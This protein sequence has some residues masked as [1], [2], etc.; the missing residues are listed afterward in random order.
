MTFQIVVVCTILS[1]LTVNC[2]KKRYKLQ[3]CE[4]VFQIFCSKWNISSEENLCSCCLIYCSVLR[5]LLLHPVASGETHAQTQDASAAEPRLVV[6]VILSP[7]SNPMTCA[8]QHETWVTLDCS[9]IILFW[10]M[11]HGS[12]GGNK[13]ETK[14][15]SVWMRPVVLLHCAFVRWLENAVVSAGASSCGELAEQHVLVQTHLCHSDFTR[16]Q[17]LLWLC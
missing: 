1:A 9:L 15:Q 14:V 12:F 4:L 13:S 3:L 17:Q 2:D 11:E 5:D 6:K 7:L 16:S 10:D 8:N